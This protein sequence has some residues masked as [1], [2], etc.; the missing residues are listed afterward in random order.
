MM[1]YNIKEEHQ[2]LKEVD[3]M[4]DYVN[5]GTD[6]FQ[7]SLN[8]EI[9][10]DKSHL[11]AKTNALFRTERRFICISRPRRFGK[12]MAANM[13]AA[14]YGVDDDASIWFEN[15][16]ITKHPSYEKHLN[17]HN[18]IMINMQEFI[19]RTGSVTQMLKVLQSKVIKE[20]QKVYPEIEYDDIND[21]IQV[22]KDIYRATKRPFVILIDEWDCLFREYKDD[23]DSQKDYLDFLRLWLKD[24]AYVG[25]AYMTGIL[26][27]KKYGSH[28]ALNMFGEYSMIDPGRF[29]D[30]FGFRDFEVGELCTNYDVDF[31]EMKKWY[32]GYFIEMGTP[33]LNPTSVSRSLENKKFASYWN[34]TETYEALKDYIK[35]NFDG[36]KDKITQ[37]LVGESITIETDS[38]ANDMTTFDNADDVLTLLVH[39]GY[40][41]YNFEDKTVTI[42]NT[43][44]RA[45]FV[46]A[47]KSL[48]WNHVVDAIRDSQKLLQAIWNQETDVVAEG[49][50]RVHE[51]NTSI[52]AYNDENALSCVLSLAL[53][54]ANDYYTIIRELPAGKGYADLVFIPRKK[55]HDKPAIIV[56]LK[57]DKNAKDAIAQIK[58]K[59]YSSALDEYQGN[60][61]LAGISY[62][63]ETKIHECMIETLEM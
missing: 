10:V 4:G 40:L 61:L 24:Q 28:S 21:F 47:I 49:I 9:Y 31:E 41:T 8:S 39:L 57:W 59:H 7:M 22:M 62:N 19:S 3:N 55:H 16:A 2:H 29:L 12:T 15:L 11:I 13:L 25:L 42:P 50:Q 27:I 33:I 32:N 43:E 38:F 1:I 14:Y 48:K 34:K 6:K 58:D 53:Y 35:L 23:K 52:L 44:V 37:M 18:V 36:L 26:P 17:K 60:V 51:Q 45:E 46:T 54:T 63:K 20:L 5:P 30:Y 56:E